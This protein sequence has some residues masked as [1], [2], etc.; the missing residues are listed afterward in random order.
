M[1]I[2]WIISI[3]MSEY[4]IRS[5]LDTSIQLNHCRPT[6]IQAAKPPKR[7]GKIPSPYDIQ[8]L[9]GGFDSPNISSK[10]AFR[11]FQ[12]PTHQLFG[13]FGMCSVIYL[14]RLNLENTN[15]TSFENG[16]CYLVLVAAS[17]ICKKE[18]SAF[19]CWFARSSSGHVNSAEVVTYGRFM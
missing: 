3:N 15:Y 11:G 6:W 10:K 18:M 1:F 14:F 13:G 12:T 17:A 4:T 2:W 7:T 16:C 5:L 19:F 8:L 9:S